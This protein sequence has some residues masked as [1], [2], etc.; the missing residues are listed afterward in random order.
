MMN[1]EPRW[2]KTQMFEALR[3][4]QAGFGEIQGHIDE[5]S[6][7]LNRSGLTP[8]LRTFLDQILGTIVATTVDV[9]SLLDE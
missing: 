1:D 7:K 8:E 9:A 2:T 6:A 3:T 4:Y 5:I